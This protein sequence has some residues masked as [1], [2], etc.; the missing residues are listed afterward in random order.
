MGGGGCRISLGEGGSRVDTWCFVCGFSVTVI[1][2]GVERS[3][4]R[5]ATAHCLLAD[6]SEVAKKGLTDIVDVLTVGRSIWSINTSP[7]TEVVYL[8]AS[9]QAK[10]EDRDILEDMKD[11]HS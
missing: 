11:V 9:M 10:R 2:S 3:W 5:K 1:K 6:S 7:D 8:S 4:D